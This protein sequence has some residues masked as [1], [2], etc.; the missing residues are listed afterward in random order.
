MVTAQNRASG[1]LPDLKNFLEFKGVKVA[2][3]SPDTV[4]SRATRGVRQLA[5]G[6][7]GEKNEKIQES[8]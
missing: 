4:Y 3:I 1:I 2:Q 8:F 7:T 6:I 5:V